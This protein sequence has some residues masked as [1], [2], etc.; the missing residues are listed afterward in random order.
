MKQKTSP[1]INRRHLLEI[2]TTV[3]TPGATLFL[4]FLIW[5]T[6]KTKNSHS[7]SPPPSFL[8]APSSSNQTCSSPKTVG[9]WSSEEDGRVTDLRCSR[10]TTKRSSNKIGEKGF[11]SKTP[12]K[13]ERD[14]LTSSRQRRRR[15]ETVERKRD[16]VKREQW[17]WWRF[18][19]GVGGSGRVPV[20]RGRSGEK[21]DGPTV[22][23]LSESESEPPHLHSLLVA[24]TLWSRLASS[25]WSLYCSHFR[26][27]EI[28]VFKLKPQE[29]QEN[30]WDCSNS[31]KD[32]N[33][34]P[35]YC[36][37]KYRVFTFFTYYLFIQEK[38]FLVQSLIS[39]YSALKKFR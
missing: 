20:R 2:I 8:T 7:L 38:R 4:F 22:Q 39:T 3:T 15:R 32:V 35:R 30:T 19:G 9:S 18:Q 25:S 33:F 6:E 37:L 21:G 1:T 31:N 13:S 23:P 27:L 36:G 5:A 16:G 29:I 24:I 14:V 17:L 12:T 28:K 10:S 34:L 11:H 26:F